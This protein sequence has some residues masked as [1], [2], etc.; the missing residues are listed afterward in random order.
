[1]YKSMESTIAD[2][3]AS[4]AEMGTF[5]EMF[6]MNELSM[7]TAKGY[8][9]TEVGTIHALGSA[10]FA[11]V[12]STVILSKEEDCH[13]AEY[14]FTLPLSR[15]KVVAAKLASVILKLFVFSVICCLMYLAGFAALGE[16]DFAG[17]II[18]FILL[19]LV[20]N[21]E[22]ASVCFMISAFSKKNKLG[23]GI[24]VALVLYMF[25]LIAKVIPKLTDVRVLSPFYYSNATYVFTGKPVET[26][27]YVLG[28]FVIVMLTAGSGV[29]Y[30]KRDLAS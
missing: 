7:A 26:F 14:T 4:F 25:D 19:Q 13:T 15:A 30:C 22:V 27:A 24:S 10:M 12:L 9:A 20:M 8:F 3:A 16:T 18:T 29:Y 21:I 28:A 17:D 6:G 5:A 23:I 1:M 11:A 2:M